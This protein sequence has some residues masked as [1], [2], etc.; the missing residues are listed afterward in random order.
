MTVTATATGPSGD[1]LQYGLTNS[2]PSWATINATTGV[3]TLNPPTSVSGGFIIDVTATD[4]TT[5]ESST[6]QSMAVTVDKPLIPPQIGSIQPVNLSSGQ[7]KTVH[8][9]VNDV[10]GD[11]LRFSL[12]NAPSWISINPTPAPSW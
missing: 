7:T 3:I 1:P 6:P 11:P 8:V 4:T 9:S 10:I 2:P 5:Q 12:N